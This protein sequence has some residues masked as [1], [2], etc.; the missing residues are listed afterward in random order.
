MQTRLPENDG[1]EIEIEIEIEIVIA[2]CVNLW[3][4]HPRLPL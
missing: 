3:K 1:G 4:T 2:Y